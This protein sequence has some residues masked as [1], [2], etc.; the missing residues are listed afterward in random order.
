MQRELSLPTLLFLLEAL[1]FRSSLA[2]VAAPMAAPSRRP[3]LARDEQEEEVAGAKECEVRQA[4]TTDTTSDPATAQDEAEA[5]GTGTN[6]ARDSEMQLQARGIVRRFID[7]TDAH[8]PLSD[9]TRAGLHFL[10]VSGINRLRY[11]PALTGQPVLSR[12][13]RLDIVVNGGPESDPRGCQTYHRIDRASSRLAVLPLA[14]GAQIDLAHVFDEAINEVLTQVYKNS[15]RRYLREN[16][17]AS[18]MW[19]AFLH[20]N[21][22]PAQPVR[23]PDHEPRWGEMLHVA[24]RTSVMQVRFVRHGTFVARALD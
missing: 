14:G 13:R 22:G 11:V 4:M 9:S 24:R 20:R 3:A 19:A 18:A 7:N 10:S 1:A 6:H 5:S 16:Q 23:A 17:R 15:F 8:I 2:T 21:V 12:S